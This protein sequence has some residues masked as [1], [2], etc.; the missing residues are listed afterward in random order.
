[1]EFCG[2]LT[3]PRCC[4]CAYTI[5]IYAYPK[6]SCTEAKLTFTSDNVPSAAA[7]TLGKSVAVPSAI[8]VSLRRTFVLL[9][10]LGS[11]KTRP[12]LPQSG[13]N[14][15]SWTDEAA[16]LLEEHTKRVIV[17]H[18]LKSSRTD[19]K[20]RVAEKPIVYYLDN[21]CPEPLASAVLEGVNWW[22]DAFQV[23]QMS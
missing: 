11:Y 14:L 1:M 23:Q 7:Q 9:P 5:R 22:D 17:R 13:F 20:L 8:T 12:Y 21:S 6:F 3:P 10:P 2:L 15:V 18:K 16:G 19:G 4:P